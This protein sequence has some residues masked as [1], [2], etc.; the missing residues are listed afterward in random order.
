MSPVPGMIHF[1]SLEFEKA[2]KSKA[3][4]VFKLV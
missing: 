3:A 2:L 1:P 4:A